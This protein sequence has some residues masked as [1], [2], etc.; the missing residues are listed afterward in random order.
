MAHLGMGI[1]DPTYVQVGAV[2]GLFYSTTELAPSLAMMV[3]V[4]W[5]RFKPGI[6]RSACV[7]AVLLGVTM[8][9][10]RT[11][12]AMALVSLVILAVT[13]FVI[14]GKKRHMLML[15][16]P[17]LLSVLV[18]AIVMLI[19]WQRIS[20][21]WTMEVGPES[22]GSGRAL[23]WHSAF[24]AWWRGDIVTILFGKGLG[25][26]L[27]ILEKSY[28]RIWCHNDFLELLLCQ[29]LV[30]LIA[31]IALLLCIIKLLCGFWKVNH[32]NAPAWALAGGFLTCSFLNGSIYLLEI[33]GT[34]VVAF[35]VMSP[36]SH[37][38]LTANRFKPV[39]YLRTGNVSG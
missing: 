34:F 22:F 21:R 37:N 24:L 27:D 35:A 6:L 15:T 10:S 29:G 20:Y 32:D 18:V 1:R 14:G 25:A 30:G 31:Y 3:P 36:I 4:I 12:A 17:V 11:A 5:V 16:T 38:L 9:F 23:F 28:G 26:S 19:G 13:D 33:I 7:F 8:T 2:S 39:K